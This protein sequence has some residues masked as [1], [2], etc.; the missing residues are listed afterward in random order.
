MGKEQ[1]GDNW[2]CFILFEISANIDIEI[3]SESLVAHGYYVLLP[4]SCDPTDHDEQECF[5]ILTFAPSTC[6]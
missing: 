4:L 1:V 3:L 5:R 6:L 2:S